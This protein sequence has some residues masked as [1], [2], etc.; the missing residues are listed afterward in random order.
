MVVPDMTRDG[1]FQHDAAPAGA[2]QIR[3]CAGAALVTPEAVR[4]GNLCVLDTVVRTTW[5]GE[6]QATLQALATSLASELELHG[7]L[8][9]RRRTATAHAALFQAFP[10]ALVTLDDH[11]AVTEWNPAAERLLGFARDEMVG[12]DSQAL[13]GQLLGTQT[14]GWGWPEIRASLAA[15]PEA[16]VVTR[17][18]HRNGHSFPAETTV[19]P[20][21]VDG[22]RLYTL[23]VR[24]CTRQESSRAALTNQE[25][26]LRAALDGV[27]EAMYI[28]DLQRRFLM[29]NAKGAEQ[30]GLSVETILD[31]TDEDLQ[32]AEIASLVRTRDEQVLTTG[33]PL[34]YEVTDVMHDGQT[35]IDCSSKTP[36]RDSTG[37]IAG[38][39]GLSIDITE[40]KTAELAIQAQAAILSQH[41]EDAQLEILQ[42]LA[43]AAEY[44]DDDTGEHMGRVGETSARLAHELGLPE[45][46]VELIRRTAPLHDVGK[47]GI[48]DTILLKPGRLTAEE[49]ETVK[50]HSQIGA[51]I[52]QGSR[53]ALVQMA[54]TIAR[55]HH[56][57]WD[58]SGYPHGLAGDA[59]PLVGR[60]VA[61]ADVLDALTSERPYKRAW[62][63]DAALAEIRAQAGRQFDPQVVDALHRLVQRGNAAIAGSNGRERVP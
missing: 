58:G 4:L 45:G 2:P 52:L 38:L 8:A 33:Q 37:Q 43:Q 40:R 14:R 10:N 9:E 47:V 41:V 57:R 29:I 5:S 61:V 55:T 23:I 18:K 60:I 20:L 22:R 36:Y 24:D 13:V 11:G 46:E 35:R 16:E 63:L 62:T 3:F 56:E 31:R 42:R 7:A 49:F 19:V 50:T 32:P 48:S 17:M 34:T 21:D 26:L 39:I 25:A 53:S 15:H 6:E 54:E 1:R 30:L 59:I 51:Q 12:R 27:P 28:K 44:R